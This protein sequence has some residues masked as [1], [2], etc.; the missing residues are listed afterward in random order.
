LNPYKL[1]FMDETNCRLF[2]QQHYAWARGHKRSVLL[3]PK[4]QSPTFNVIATMGMDRDSPGRMLLHYVII[5]PRRDYRGVPKTFKAYEFRH[6][7]AGIDVGYSVAQIARDLTN[8]QL[9]QLMLEQHLRLAPGLDSPPTRE[10]EMR[11][12]LQQVRTKGKVGCYR[13]MPLHQSYLGGSIKAFRSS[14]VDVVEY[15]ETLLIP[16]I[17]NRKLSGLVSACNEDSDGLQGCPDNGH[18]FSIPYTD[19]KDVTALNLIENKQRA[20]RR[21][22]TAKRRLVAY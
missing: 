14:A 21:A 16:W 20:Q 15:I 18:H 12:L 5:P 2:D 19:P 11:K 6:P 13:Q 4:G 10:R 9:E 22:Q 3:K 1:L 17:A 8:D 7:K